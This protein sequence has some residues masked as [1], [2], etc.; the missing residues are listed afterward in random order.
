MELRRCQG[1]FYQQGPLSRY[2]TPISS[3]PVSVAVPSCPKD[4]KESTC[5]ILPELGPQT[6]DS[7]YGLQAHV[8]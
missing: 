6:H 1:V 7:R 5:P 8:L 2:I 4:A 3:S